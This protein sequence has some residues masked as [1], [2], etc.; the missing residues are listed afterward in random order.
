MAQSESTSVIPAADARPNSWGFGDG[1][2]I[3]W[4]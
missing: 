1:Q 4:E 3:P 2:A